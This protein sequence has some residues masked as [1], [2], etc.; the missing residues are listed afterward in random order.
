M[1]SDDVV[2]AE[3]AGAGAVEGGLTSLSASRVD[4]RQVLQQQLEPLLPLAVQDLRSALAPL[5]ASLAAS[6]Q[7]QL[8]KLCQHDACAP[9]PQCSVY[10]ALMRAHVR[11]GLALATWQE[12]ALAAAASQQQQQGQSVVGVASEGGAG[13]SENGAE[14]GAVR[15]A[16]AEWC[17]Q[18]QQQL[19]DACK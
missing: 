12:H 11:S 6:L 8:A 19:L 7:G 5:P 10:Q 9:W 14:R 17:K 18:L 2:T 1:A 16:V 13:Q 4:W 15:G 3:A